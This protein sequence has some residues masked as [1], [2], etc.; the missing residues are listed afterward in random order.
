[1]MHSSED[2]TNHMLGLLKKTGPSGPTGPTSIKLF[3]TNEKVGTN[4]CAKVGPVDLDWSQPV[5]VTG[6]GKTP[7]IQSPRKPGTTG[8]SGTTILQ[9]AASEAKAGAEPSEWYAIFAELKQQNCPDWLSPDRWLALLLDAESFLNRWGNA[10][11]Q[12]GWTAL[13][14]FSVHPEA[15]SA[16]FDKMGLAL[17]ICGGEVIVLTAQSATIRRASGAVLTYRRADQTGAVCIT[18]ATP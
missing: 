1:M 18:E 16:R 17:L 8:T 10:A 7:L 9:R 15:P 14:L 6:P 12:L 13:D 4:Q 11:Y 5:R 3:E 2:F